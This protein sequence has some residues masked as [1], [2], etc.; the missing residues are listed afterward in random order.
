MDPEDLLDQEVE[1]IPGLEGHAEANMETL[2]TLDALDV[3]YRYWFR[4][5]TVCLPLYQSNNQYINQSND[6]SIK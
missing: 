2:K 1:I 4:C 5:V 3:S 6:P